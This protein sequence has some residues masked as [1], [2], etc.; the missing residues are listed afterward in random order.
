MSLPRLTGQVIAFS[1]FWL[2]RDVGL[3]ISDGAV[4]ELGTRPF[5]MLAALLEARG[6][7]VSTVEL[8]ELVWPGSTIDA[9]TVQAQISAIR[10]ALDDARDLIVTV[11][12]RGYRFAGEIRVLDTPDAGLDLA[13]ANAGSIAASLANSFAASEAAGPSAAAT[14]AS[15]SASTY[16]AT[17]GAAGSGLSSG[18]SYGAQFGAQF[19]ARLGAPLGTQLGGQFGTPSGTRSASSPAA[20]WDAPLASR[21]AAAPA[22]P[23]TPAFPALMPTSASASL[24]SQSI[25]PSPFI[26]R[27]AELSELLALVPTRRIVTL[28]GASGVGK[29]RLAIE[30]ASH[31]GPQFPDGDFCAALASLAQPDRVANAIGAALGLEPAGDLTTSANLAA[32]IGERRLLLIVDHCDHL[33]EAAAAL[34]D[35]LVVNTTGLHVIA[36][37]ES[38]LFIGGEAAVPVAALRVPPEQTDET[39]ATLDYDALRLLFT[40][41]AH[42]LKAAGSHAP[43]ADV[44]QLAPATF[45]AAALIC[46]RVDGVPFA[47]ELAAATIAGQVRSGMPPEDAI[48]AF[49]RE[50]DTVMTHRSG[51]R[52]IVLPRAAIVHVMLDLS[53]AALEA[54]TRTMLRRLG[55]FATAFSQDAAYEM[56]SAFGSDYGFEPPEAHQLEHQL[57]TLMDAG[58]VNAVDCDGTLRLRLP[59]AVRRFALD[60]LERNRESAEAGLHHA[61]FVA[62]DMARRFG[63]GVAMATAHSRYDIDALRAALEWAVSVDKVELCTELLDNT[64]PIWAALAL[65]DEYIGWVRAVLARVDSVSM[66][67]IRDEMR[68]RAV[69]ARALTLKR[70]ASAE[71]VESWQRTYDLANICADTPYRLRAL[72]CLVMCALDVGEIKH[73]RWLSGQFSEIAPIAHSPVVSINARRIEGIVT[74]YGGDFD[75]ALRLLAPVVG[76]NDDADG[77]DEEM[78]REA[79]AV[80]TSYGLSLHLVAR[81]IHA[82]T[83]WLVGEP[84]TAAPLRVTIRD[85]ADESEPL[86]CCI[87]LS[88][89]CALAALDDDIALTESCAAA[90]VT[91]ARAAGV[92]RWLRV[93]LDFQLW[94]DARRGDEEAALRL[95]GGA[96]KR[97]ARERVQVPDIAFIATLLPRIALRGAPELAATLGATLRDAVTRSERTGELWY[98]PEL[99]RLEAM[100]RLRSGD[101]PGTVRPLLER[102]LQRARQ[103]GAQRLALRISVDLE[104]LEASAG[105]GL[106]RVR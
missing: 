47:L 64:A 87:A 26:G 7:V 55:I 35:T 50:L 63:A 56:L 73:C 79:N 53:Y 76:L 36:T 85:P 94:L 99:L 28:T 30:A 58:L 78:S 29:T 69:L 44:S 18:F 3:L 52:R 65:V 72:F 95:I 86:A 92:K 104:A 60:A 25:D 10:R 22:A 101:D 54:P 83:L 77:V 57:H 6:R 91:R 96:A 33:S 31:L 80:A 39:P 12:G 90:L 11:A 43:L 105:V 66:R 27:H 32:Q 49:A 67:R 21:L 81:A 13:A 62:R 19:G 38:P 34:I 98:V 82:V 70:S 23:V 42:C 51:G 20:A 103:H 15:S 24:R 71:I 106:L 5:A 61:Q 74:A 68:L 46:R 75:T 102:A 41:L 89:A 16:G 45:A 84:Q 97:I 1:R 17:F 8:R 37:C 40:R 9:N 14:L 2:A 59:P 48:V 4:I 88:L 100:V 93:G